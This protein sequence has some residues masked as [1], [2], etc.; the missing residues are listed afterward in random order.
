VNA[1]TDGSARLVPFAYGFRPFFMAALLF[2]PISVLAWLFVRVGGELP[3][4]PFPPQLWHGHEMVFGFAGAAVAGFLLTAVPSWTGARGFAG[5]PLIALA[6]LWLTGRLAFAFAADVPAWLLA[7]VE[8]AFLPGLALLVAPPLLRAKNRNTPLLIVVLV[9]WVADAAFVHALMQ[10]D[11]AAASKAVRAAIDV[12]LLLI[13]IIGG[14]IVPAFTAN[15]LRQ[16]GIVAPLRTRGWVE[17]TVIAAMALRV[18]VDVLAPFH[19]VTALV[20]AVAAL[21]H[22][23]RLAGWQG[24]RT[25]KDPIVWVLHAAYAWLPVGLALQAI[26]VT[27]AANGASQWMHALTAGAVTLMIVAVITRASLGHT[28]RPLEVARPVALAY[29]LLFAATAVRVAGGGLPAASYEWTLRIAGALWLTAFLIIAVAYAPI[30]LRPR[31]DGKP[32]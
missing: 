5:R 10:A 19:I 18:V 13:T 16:R 9:L 25:G 14:R 7:A 30:L 29:G 8:L 21:A 32:G 11:P 23:V 4:G 26:H 12:L 28:G 6:A 2:A 20:A 31:V 17:V 15:A 22:G 24:M 1:R 27:T 3:L